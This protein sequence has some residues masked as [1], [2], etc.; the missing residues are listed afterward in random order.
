I[1]APMTPAPSTATFLTM[2]LDTQISFAGAANMKHEF[3]P[4]K[5]LRRWDERSL[6]ALYPGCGGS[7]HALPQ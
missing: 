4:G 1:W 7:Q 6:Y 3:G 5:V 2:K